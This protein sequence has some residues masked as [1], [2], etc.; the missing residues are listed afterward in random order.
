MRPRKLMSEKKLEAIRTRCE[1]ATHGP[2]HW[3]CGEQQYEYESLSVESFAGIDVLSADDG[4]IIV[5]S[6]DA[7]FIARARSDISKLLAEIDL[8]KTRLGCSSE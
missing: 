4:L 2:W 7:D 1:K 8:L 6:E 5:S 3:H